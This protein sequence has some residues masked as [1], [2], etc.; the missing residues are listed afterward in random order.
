MLSL[1]RTHTAAASQSQGSGSGVGQLLP[2]EPISLP[3]PSSLPSLLPSI[4]LPS[5]SEHSKAT[6]TTVT[7]Q[8]LVSSVSLSASE[9][10]SLH[11]SPLPY[12]L[13]LSIPPA[14]LILLSWEQQ[15]GSRRCTAGADVL[16]G[17]THHLLLGHA[18]FQ[19]S[20]VTTV[21]TSP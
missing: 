12:S 4:D 5:A 3:P 1:T 16:S 8:L 13:P 11:S 15:C 19:V 2:P 7:S 6:H 17:H 9:L 14:S 10:F 20:G 21:L 18:L